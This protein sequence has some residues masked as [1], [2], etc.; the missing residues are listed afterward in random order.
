MKVLACQINVPDITVSVE[1][2]NHV[3]RVADLAVAQFENS[4]GAD[5]ILLPELA[6]IDYSKAAFENLDAL[7]EDLDGRSVSVFGNVAKTTGAFVCFG[8]PRRGEDGSFHI[9][10]VVIDPKGLVIGYYDKMHVAQFGASIEK[11][12]FKP[13]RHLLAFDVAG[14]RVAPIICYDHRF[15]ELTTTLCRD[16]GVD[17]ILHP[18]AFYR[19]ASFQGWHHFSITRAI[20]NQV[21]L[22]SLNRAGEM[23]GA[24]LFAPPWL[25]DGHQP[26]KFGNEEICRLLDVDMA[27]SREIRRQYPFRTDRID[28]YTTLPLQS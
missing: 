26:V 21:H 24:S 13:G 4:G 18:V 6:T 11:P 23:Y 15:P 22:L 3:Q 9:S 25:E 28:D 14:V 20:E 7:G 5:L 12:Y 16:H 8:M 17:L 19:D 2:D 27:Y 1:R 10:Q